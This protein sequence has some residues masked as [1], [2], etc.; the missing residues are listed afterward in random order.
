MM[1]LLE[2]AKLIPEIGS[3]ALL[4]AVLLIVAFPKLRKKFNGNSETNKILHEFK[5]NHF[6]SINDKLDKNNFLLEK[7]LDRIA[8]QHDICL[9]NKF[10]LENLNKK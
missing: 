5:S 9:K 1:N 8:K 2:T 4:I 10:I 6:H 7:I 3:T